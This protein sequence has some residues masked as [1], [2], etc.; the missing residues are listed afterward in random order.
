MRLVDSFTASKDIFL[1]FGDFAEEENDNP[2]IL[3]NVFALSIKCIEAC[4]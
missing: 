1:E 3:W 4:Q 2:F